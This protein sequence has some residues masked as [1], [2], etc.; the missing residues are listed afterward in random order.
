MKGI[1]LAGGSGTRLAPMTSVVSKQILPVY[2]K[3][4][5]YYPLATLM[6]AGIRDILIISTPHDLPFMQKLL[7]DGTQLGITLSYLPQARPEGIAQAFLIGESFIGKDSV[8]LILG[9]NLFHGITLETSHQSGGHIFACKVANP[10]RYGVVELQDGKPVSIEEKPS[11]P[12]SPYAVTGLYSYDAD[13]VRIAKTLKPSK[14]GELEITD[15]NNAYMKNGTLKVDILGHES[16]WLDTGTP[17]SLLAASQFVQELQ[18][19]T[20]KQIACIEEI[21][22]R[23]GF[24]DRKQFATLITAFAGNEYGQYL[25]RVLNAS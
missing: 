2:D 20:G 19:K 22:L 10:N 6:E 16:I 8:C 1:I 7:G 24:V 4:T 9:D 17:D 5:L 23:K 3:P 25:T 14:R 11:R 13:V 18:R 12:K 15:V 21:A